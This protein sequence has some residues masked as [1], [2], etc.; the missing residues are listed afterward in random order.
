MV[1]SSIAIVAVVLCLLII[2]AGGVALLVSG[3]R[4]RNEL[5]SLRGEVETLKQSVGA[6]CSSA[7]GVDKRVIRLERRGR[8]LEERQETI[9]HNKAGDHPPYA[10]AIRLVQ[11]G[12]SA[13]QLVNELG[14][15]GGEADL[16]V[17]L[18]R[19]SQA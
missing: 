14:I 6:L 10:E 1:N 15:S 5:S 2:L 3:R 7:V 18:H 4:F 13:E 11:Q 12:A 8:D 16:I 17:M 19:N 9:E